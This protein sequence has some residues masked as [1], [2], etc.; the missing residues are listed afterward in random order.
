M[1][2][3]EVQERIAYFTRATP[4]PYTVEHPGTI[5][6]RSSDEYTIERETVQAVTDYW[7]KV[8]NYV[9][10]DTDAGTLPP[11]KQEWLENVNDMIPK[12]MYVSDELLNEWYYDYVRCVGQS[13]LNYQLLIRGNRDLPFSKKDVQ[14]FPEWWTNDEYK[15]SRLESFTPNRH[16]PPEHKHGAR[17]HIENDG[18]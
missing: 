3:S 4:A 8:R 11:L 7:V 16:R 12:E 2:K 5:L 9:E 17:Q 18:R 1:K 14:N 10:E 6:S 13:K 15:M